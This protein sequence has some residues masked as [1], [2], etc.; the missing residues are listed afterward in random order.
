VSSRSPA[1]QL[2]ATAGFG[3]TAASDTRERSGTQPINISPCFCGFSKTTRNELPRWASL[4]TAVPFGSTTN[5]LG[6]PGSSAT[7][8]TAALSGTGS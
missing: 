2:T 6:L 7:L 5:A 4:V 3:A 1:A 8:V